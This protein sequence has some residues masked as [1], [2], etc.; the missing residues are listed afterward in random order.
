MDGMSSIADQQKKRRKEKNERAGD[1]RPGEQRI[2]K[3]M[4]GVDRN[5]EEKGPDGPEHGITDRRKKMAQMSGGKFDGGK[6]DRPLAKDEPEEDR[7]KQGRHSR[8]SHSFQWRLLAAP[9]ERPSPLP[10]RG[11]SPWTAAPDRKKTADRNNHRYPVNF[12]KRIRLRM[13]AAAKRK[14]SRSVRPEIQATFSKWSGK[15]EKRSAAAKADRSAPGKHS[16]DQEQQKRVDHMQQDIGQMESGRVQPPDFEIDPIGEH[17]QR[18]VKCV[19]LEGPLPPMD[20]P[21]R[22]HRKAA[23]GISPKRPGSSIPRF[24]SPGCGRPRRNL[25][26]SP[27][28]TGKD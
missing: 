10:P 24:P 4:I 13:A 3:D 21:R 27:A 11:R 26:S 17:G 19:S 22:F 5:A 15:T 28:E 1:S 8:R 12:K 6:S 2:A 25:P 7:Q 16:E 9:E 20:P 18:P 23:A 14:E